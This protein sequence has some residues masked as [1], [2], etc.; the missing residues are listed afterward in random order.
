[1]KKKRSVLYLSKRERQILDVVY[2]LGAAS[3]ADIVAG[4]PDEANDASIR[5]LV[6]VLEE[7]GYLAHERRGQH[8]VYR[9]T[10][11]HREA[12]RSALEHVIDVFFEG[13]AHK[14]VSALVDP[15]QRRLSAAEREQLMKLIDKAAGE[16]R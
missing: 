16:G 11:P 7:K 8:H 6:R 10:I 12:S 2:R 5:K 14:A 13:S 3:A 9:P 4:I 15:A 1:V